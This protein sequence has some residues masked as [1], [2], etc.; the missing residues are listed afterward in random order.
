MVTLQFFIFIL[1]I[2]INIVLLL[3][4]FR[5]KKILEKNHHQ[6]IIKLQQQISLQKTQIN[7]RT[8]GLQE[9]NFLK[10]NLNESLQVQPE[11]KLN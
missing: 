11:I 3:C 7:Y 4:F 2:S 5:N 9:Y 8:K 10:Y 1:F 6:Q